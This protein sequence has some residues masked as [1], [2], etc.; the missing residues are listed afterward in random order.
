[1]TTFEILALVLL[2]IILGTVIANLLRNPSTGNEVV[3]DKLT[4]LNSSLQT[5]LAG[6]PAKSLAIDWMD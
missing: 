3:K 6:C 4:D 2:V 5:G 1:M